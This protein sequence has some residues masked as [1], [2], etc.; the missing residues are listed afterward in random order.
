MTPGLFVG[1]TG[2]G[3][4]KTYVARAL[5]R[6]LSREAGRAVAALKPLETGCDPDPLDALALAGACGR[7][8]LAHH[9]GLY[10]V[11]PPLAPYAATLGGLPAPRG[12]GRRPPGRGRRR[13]P[14]ALGR[15]P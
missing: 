15:H 12:G 14:G 3:V 13:R 10:R 2:T 4:G 7:P 8:E 6:A 1:G 11:P 5:A 9:R